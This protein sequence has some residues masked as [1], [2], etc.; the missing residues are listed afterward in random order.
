MCFAKSCHGEHRRTMRNEI[1][2]EPVYV[3]Q[4]LVSTF[5]FCRKKKVEKEKP[6]P[7]SAPPPAPSPPPRA[8]ADAHPR[9]IDHVALLFILVGFLFVIK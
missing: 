3:K 7:L 8:V 1:F 5:F 9:G 4:L 2:I 6:P